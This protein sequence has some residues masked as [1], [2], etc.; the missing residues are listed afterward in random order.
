VRFPRIGDHP[1]TKSAV[2]LIGLMRKD[3]VTMA[4]GAVLF[5][6]VS[7]FIGIYAIALAVRVGPDTGFAA[8]L[9]FEIGLTRDSSLSESLNHGVA[10]LA[11]LIFF[12]GFVEH[13][14]RSQL[15]L[16]A[17]M[18]F[19]WF[20]DSWSYHERVGSWLVKSYDL[21]AIGGLRQQDSGEVAAWSIAALALFVLLL[22]SIRSRR[23]IVIVVVTLLAFMSLLFFGVAIDL[24]EILLPKRYRNAVGVV[25]DGGEMLSTVLIATCA[26]GIMRNADELPATGS[27]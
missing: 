2:S 15:W 25:E 22:F 18:V 26:V 9:V 19:V 23:D 20:D 4:T 5:G 11:A 27:P 1:V 3:R 13:H 16:S 6:V 8:T 21:P 7:C 17:L 10:F 14:L 12:M 24:V